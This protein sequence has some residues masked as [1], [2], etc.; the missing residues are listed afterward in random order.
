MRSTVLPAAC[1]A[2]TDV[3][4]PGG[5]NTVQQPAAL[6]TA[7][8]E[9][10]TVPLYRLDGVVEAVN[11]STV[12]AETQGQVQEILLDVDDYVEKDAVIA[13]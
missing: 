1:A 3:R 4:S 12:S 5:S 6:E 11:R 2:T 8:A 7:V 10:R 13:R 9:Y